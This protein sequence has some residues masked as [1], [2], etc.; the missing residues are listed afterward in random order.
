MLCL[1]EG[2]CGFNLTTQNRGWMRAVCCQQRFWTDS[3]NS[4]CFCKLDDVI[5]R[6]VRN[7]H[8]KKGNRYIGL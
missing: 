8:Q 1:P 5:D 3:K 7:G 4:G 2:K 6:L